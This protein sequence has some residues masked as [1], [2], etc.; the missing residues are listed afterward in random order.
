MDFTEKSKNIFCGRR[1]STLKLMLSRPPKNK[2]MQNF[3]SNLPLLSF[4]QWPTIKYMA[5]AISQSLAITC[6]IRPFQLNSSYRNTTLL[7]LIF[8]AEIHGNWSSWSSWS[9]CCGGRAYKLRECNNPS[10]KNGGRSCEGPRRETKECTS[11][12]ISQRL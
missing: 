5:F 4:R 12:K 7:S 8:N 1:K 6:N 3:F 9:N 2:D 10:P 11:G